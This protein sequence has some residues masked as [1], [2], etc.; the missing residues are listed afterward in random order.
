[1]TRHQRPYQRANGSLS[2]DEEIQ[3]LKHILFSDDEETVISQRILE[4][5]Y[6]QADRDRL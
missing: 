4:L 1:M 2:V 3:L 5:Y 6:T